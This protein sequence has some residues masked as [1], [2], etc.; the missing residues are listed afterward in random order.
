[1]FDVRRLSSLFDNKK[2]Y[3]KVMIVDTCTT[4]VYYA[5][6]YFCTPRKCKS[7][8]CS[9]EKSEI[10]TTNLALLSTKMY[11]TQI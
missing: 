1:M 3:N 4:F 5:A 11:P 7:V 6:N 9:S 10:H 2:G 8:T